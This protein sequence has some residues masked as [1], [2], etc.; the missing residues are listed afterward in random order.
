MT[1]EDLRPDPEAMLAE[2]REKTLGKL[3]IFLGMA[4]GVGKTYAMLAEA[5]QRKTAGLDVLI[6]WV[7]THKRKDTEALTRGLEILPRKRIEYNGISVDTLDIDEILRRHPSVVVIDEMPHSNPPGSRHAKRWQDIEEILDMGIDVWSALNIQHLESLNG[8]VARVTGVTVSETVPDRIFDEA[9]E[10]RFID[11]PPDDLINRLQ[12]GKIY[13][14]KVVE[15]AK[16][17]FFRKSNLVA[18]RELALRC[19]ASR[20]ESQIRSERLRSTRRSVEDTNYGLLLAMEFVSEEAV[21]EAAR[22]ARALSA[23]WHVVW[24]DGTE[25]E[26]DGGYKDFSS[27][28]VLD[29]VTVLGGRASLARASVY[30]GDR[31]AGLYM[32]NANARLVNCIVTQNVAEG[33]GGG[34][35]LGGGRIESSLLFNNSSDADG[36][37]VYVD[38]SGLVLRSMLTNN[39]AGNGAAVCLARN[40]DYTDG[41][42]HPEYLILSTS[43]VSNNTA[44][45]NGAVYC[46]E[47]GVLTQNTIVNNSAPRALDATD[48]EATRT[49]GL[50]IDG[51]ALVIN[52]I[53]WNNRANGA[54]VA[55][56]DIPMYAANP[57]QSAV[58]FLSSAVSG[59]NN[60]VWNNTLQ[61]SL[62]SLAASNSGSEG[63]NNPDFL[64]GGA[65]SDDALNTTIGVQPSWN[66]IV[67]FWQPQQGSNLRAVGMTLASFPD[68]VLLAPELDIAGLL[69]SLCGRQLH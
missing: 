10:V 56:N 38:N 34:V 15:R 22:L 11:L 26:A 27:V 16:E 6:G 44:R 45:K 23:R 52:N 25:L 53:L 55:G 20:M 35:Y 39:A 63:E 62:S 58:R 5:H 24:F 61:Q 32:D 59:M 46:D 19:M 69:A 2:T 65:M 21:R 8:V 1:Q 40:G 43:V 41:D 30:C 57:T 51:Y 54:G 18:L 60:A 9:D 42:P 36:G 64:P 48:P 17:A 7:D 37:A 29:G 67:Y 66:E 31:G 49:G 28:T 12:A 3:R 68:E 13:L 33:P 14:P 47:G 4:P 50:F